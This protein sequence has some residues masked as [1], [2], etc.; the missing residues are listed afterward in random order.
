MKD[1]NKKFLFSGLFLLSLA[2][3]VRWLVGSELWF[4]SLLGTGILLKGIFLFN[5]FR[6]KGFH[7]G[8]GFSLILI[9]VVMILTSLLF[10]NIFPIPLLRNVLFYGA[11]ALKATGVVVLILQ[12]R[13]TP[14]TDCQEK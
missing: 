2:F 9:G 13:E 12:R 7:L 8:L 14:V 1:H 11:L 10:K 3:A 4:Y 5:V 6:K